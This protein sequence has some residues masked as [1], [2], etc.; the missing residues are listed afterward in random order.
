MV[1]VALWL[2]GGSGVAQVRFAPAWARKSSFYLSGHS[3]EKD[4]TCDPEIAGEI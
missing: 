3:P 2:R 4:E 1:E